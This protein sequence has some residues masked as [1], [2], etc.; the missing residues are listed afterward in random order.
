MLKRQYKYTLLW[1]SEQ[2]ERNLG[3]SIQGCHSQG[4]LICH[5]GTRF[6]Y[7][8]WY[9]FLTAGLGPKLISFLRTTIRDIFYYNYEINSKATST[10]S[11]ARDPF[12]HHKEDQGTILR[13]L[14]DARWAGAWS[15]W[16]CWWTRWTWGSV[17]L[18]CS[19]MEVRE[20]P[21]VGGL[22]VFV[23]GNCMSELGLTLSSRMWIGSPPLLFAPLIV[24]P[25]TS[26]LSSS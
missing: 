9:I 22:L 21:R 7:I 3:K 26:F 17:F 24:S 14:S 2:L 19:G 12:A 10:D 11:W 16:G 6:C 4:T 18:R 25:S 15:T 20:A 23:E 1:G 13:S 5:S 8:V